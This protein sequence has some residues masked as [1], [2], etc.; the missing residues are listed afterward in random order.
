MFG[1][2]SGVPYTKGPPKTGRWPGSSYF[3]ADH[4][5][6]ANFSTVFQ[7]LSTAAPRHVPLHPAPPQQELLGVNLIWLAGFISILHAADLLPRSSIVATHAPVPKHLVAGLIRL[8]PFPCRVPAKPLIIPQSSN[9]SSYRNVLLLRPVEAASGVAWQ[10]GN[11]RRP[12]GNARYGWASLTSLPPAETQTRRRIIFFSFSLAIHQPQRELLRAQQQQQC[13]LPHDQPQQSQQQLASQQTA[14][15]EPQPAHNKIP[16]QETA[17]ESHPPSYEQAKASP[18]GQPPAGLTPGQA[19]TVTPLNQLGDTP[20]WIDCPFCQTRTKT[21]VRKEGGNMQ[22]IVGAVLCLVCVCLTC[23]PCM[24]HW[25]EDTEWHCSHCKK[26]VAIRQNEGAIQVLAPTQVVYSQYGHQNTMNN[27]Q[28]QHGPGQ[29][30]Q[31]SMPQHPDVAH[32]QEPPTTA[33]PN[34]QQSNPQHPHASQPQ[35]QEIQPQPL[36]TPSHPPM[37]VKN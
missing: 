28:Q 33:G 35:N 23:L 8:A 37:D 26:K 7:A 4:H 29:N 3:Q 1:Q 17:A 10:S 18:A 27:P 36:Q 14:P 25:F 11:E 6:I 22:I 20:E 16:I 12:E 2:F 24:L 5:S 15:T 30:V 21:T 19:A 32:Q 31:H 34:A 13:E 9:G